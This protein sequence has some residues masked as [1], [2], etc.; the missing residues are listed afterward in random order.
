[1]NIDRLS[2]DMRDGAGGVVNASVTI[3]ADGWYMWH[4]VGILWPI[5]TQGH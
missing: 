5:Q 1:M 3:L 4:L 2:V